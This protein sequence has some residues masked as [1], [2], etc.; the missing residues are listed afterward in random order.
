VCPKSNGN[1]FPPT[2]LA[3]TNAEP[4]LMVTVMYCSTHK[5]PEGKT[6]AMPIPKSAD[7]T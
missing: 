3:I 1:I 6:E 7:P 4:I 2:E 5:H